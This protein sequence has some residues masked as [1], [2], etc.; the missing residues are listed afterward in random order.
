MKKRKVITIWYASDESGPAEYFG[1]KLARILYDPLFA[2][3]LYRDDIV[4]LDVS[5]AEV[6]HQW[7]RIVEIVYSR[8]E[9]K[10]VLQFDKEQQAIV[11]NAI[12]AQLGGECIVLVPPH[13]GNRGLLKVGHPKCVDVELLAEAVGI[14]QDEDPDQ[15]A[16]SPTPPATPPCQEQN[17]PQPS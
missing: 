17:T 5:H 7:P 16:T 14:S 8:H 13:Q 2:D 12:L 1:G 3:G 9:A 4:R 11:L 15:T 10:T 6:D